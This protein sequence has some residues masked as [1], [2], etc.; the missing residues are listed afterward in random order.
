M[1]IK[2][3]IACK[4]I[5]YVSAV[6][7]GYQEVIVTMPSRTK[8]NEIDKYG[9]KMK[10][11]GVKEISD[12]FEVIVKIPFDEAIKYIDNEEENNNG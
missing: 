5:T 6:E 11:I 10:Y 12:P 7:N 1:Y 4:E 2:R 3:K 8:D 9:K